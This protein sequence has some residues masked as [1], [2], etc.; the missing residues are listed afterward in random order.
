MH[1]KTIH[2][3]GKEADVTVQTI[4]GWIARGLLKTTRMGGRHRVTEPQW[5]AFM[6]RC[7]PVP[8]PEAEANTK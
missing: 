8:E 7:N 2:A 6:L 4:Y 3:I 1:F 5:K